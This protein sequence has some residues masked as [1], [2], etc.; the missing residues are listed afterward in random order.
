MPELNVALAHLAVEH[1]QPEKN[2]AELLRLF[3]RAADEG[4]RIAVGPEMSL[5]GYCFESREEI[6]PFAQEA[7]G[8]AGTALGKLAGE[9]GIYLVAAWAER[10]PLTGIFYNSAFVFGPDGALVKRYRKISAESRWAC[11]GPA[12]QNN[13]FDT[14]W[15]RMGL[16]ICSDSYYAL[17]SRVTAVKGADLIFVPA[18]WPPGGLDPSDLWRQRARE[19]G[20]YLLAANRTGQERRMDCR[21][22]KSCA[23]APSGAALLDRAADATALMWARLP[24]DEH[25]H[26]AG[27]RR[28]GILASRRREACYR[29]VGNFSV[30]E[31]LTG[32][33][34]LP[35]PGR[36]NIHCL[37]PG[38]DENPVDCLI[39]RRQ[40]FDPVSLIVLPSRSYSAS[41]RE[42]I[43]NFAETGEIAVVAR[44]GATGRLC[45]WTKGGERSGVWPSSG[46][47][48][49]AADLPRVEFGPA[50]IL[51]ASLDELIHPEL[52][53]AAAK[54]GCDLAVASE[55]RMDEGRAAL[56]ALRPIEQIAVAACA[57]DGAAIGLIPQGHEAGRGVRTF[58]EG[59]CSCVLDTAET[60][61]KKFQERIDYEAL[62]SWGPS[63]SGDFC[64][65]AGHA[66][67]QVPEDRFQKTAI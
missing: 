34:K 52:A 5:S 36:L 15:G 37:I 53:L 11:P 47:T 26:L 23:A 33:L 24:L 13:V 57:R 46:A 62:F 35:S 41:E 17:P 20:V 63:R 6:A 14:P 67:G 65:G 29:A 12:A 3:H 22:A 66:L 10:D 30:I 59:L 8:P 61:R 64:K 1:G 21:A 4:A 51:L 31:N 2:L 48:A 55:S 7:D 32:F 28:R 9:R 25:G 38:A 43:G 56:V 19:N 18:N 58:R 54:W 42:G 44:D 16:L 49:D 50:R 40:D 60:R 27:L 45:F 39:H